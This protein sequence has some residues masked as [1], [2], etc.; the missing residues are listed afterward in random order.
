MRQYELSKRLHVIIVFF[1]IYVKKHISQSL[2]NLNHVTG[3]I[4][5]NVV[6]EN[7]TN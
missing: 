1:N 7:A 3:D 2:E 5:G 6:S 4:Y